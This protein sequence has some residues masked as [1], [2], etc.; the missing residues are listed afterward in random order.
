VK[1]MPEHQ[2]PMRGG[3]R[4]LDVQCMKRFEKSFRESSHN[5]QLEIVDAI[6]YPEKAKPGMKQGV[7]FF[8]RRRNLTA[9]GFDPS[10]IGI[11]DLGYV[12][13]RPNQ[14]KGVPDD[15]LKQYGLAYTERELKECV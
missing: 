15:V 11:K 3:L 5:Q 4:W 7:S 10:E 2:V 8:N 1:D 12:G 9:S 6:A 14:W 13:N